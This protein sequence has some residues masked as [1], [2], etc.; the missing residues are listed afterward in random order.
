MSS[1][2]YRFFSWAW[3]WERVLDVGSGDNPH[4]RADTLVDSYLT[5]EHRWGPLRE[6]DRVL[7]VDARKF[8]FLDKEFDVVLCAHCLEHCEDPEGVVHEITRVGKRGVLEVPTPYL[9]IWFQPS[10]QHRWIFAN[11]ANT[12]LYAPSPAFIVPLSTKPITVGLLRHNPFFRT[13]YLL[14]EKA[15]RVRIRWIDH[16]SIERSS[17]Q[18]VLSAQAMDSSNI[19]IATLIAQLTGRCLAKRLDQIVGRCRRLAT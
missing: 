15:F 8:P 4:P 16:L 11:R 7:L 2:P 10:A 9:D 1:Q 6:P 5:D 3:P 13:A 19:R 18:E 14:D 12:L 17:T